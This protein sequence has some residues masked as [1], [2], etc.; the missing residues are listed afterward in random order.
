MLF[1]ESPELWIKRFM[2]IRDSDMRHE[3]RYDIRDPHYSGMWIRLT[4]STTERV[5]QNLAAEG[6]AIER[7]SITRHRKAA[8]RPAR[9]LES[10][11]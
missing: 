2:N 9:D 1:L 10:R 3:T 4:R 11:S 5:A 8:V 7:R 6:T